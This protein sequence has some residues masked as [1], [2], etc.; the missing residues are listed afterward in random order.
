MIENH[1]ENIY[2]YYRNTCVDSFEIYQLESQE[3]A[4]MEGM[5][6]VPLT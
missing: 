5:I 1:S 2:H 6:F 4:D 3:E